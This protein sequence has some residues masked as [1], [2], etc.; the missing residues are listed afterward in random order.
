MGCS[1]LLNSAYHLFIHSPASL[2]IDPSIGPPPTSQP[3]IWGVRVP[4]EPNAP[5]LTLWL[6]GVPIVAQQ[7]KNLTSIHEAV[8]SIPGL[9]QLG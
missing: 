6:C 1:W 3:A 9:A 5:E 4:L 8:G 7:V 2:P